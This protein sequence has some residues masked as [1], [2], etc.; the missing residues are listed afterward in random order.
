MASQKVRP[1]VTAFFQDLD[2]LDV[3][4]RNDLDG[5]RGKARELVDG[6]GEPER[7]ESDVC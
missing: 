3:G 2:I 6:G 7:P 1:C 4:M 5:L